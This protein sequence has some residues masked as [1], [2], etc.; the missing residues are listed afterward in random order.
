MHP[1]AG[2]RSGTLVNALLHHCRNLSG[3]GGRLR[4]GIVHRLDK[5][6]SGV[7]VVAKDDESHYALQRQF[8]E[9]KVRRIYKAL[10]WGILPEAKGEI[11]TYL[12]R[13][14]RDRKKFVVAR[15]GKEAITTF[16]VITYY[17]FLTFVKVQLKTGRTHQIRV[18]FNYIHHPIFGDPEYSGRIKQL[19]SLSR[20]EYR[21]IAQ[22][23]LKILP[24]QALHATLL[25]FEHPVT[26]QWMEFEVPIPPPFREVLDFLEERN[27]NEPEQKM[28]QLK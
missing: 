9:K 28:K 14:K 26:H 7:L 1:G 12:N 20:Q 21:T 16:E 18:H 23:L 27:G 6:T 10:V 15:E 3:V 5:N 25:G 4:P 13:S 19:A 2:V 17:E 24:Y 11:T 8:S 22:Q